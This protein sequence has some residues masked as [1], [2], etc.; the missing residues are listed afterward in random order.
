[1]E[2]HLEEMIARLPVLAPCRETIL[3][4]AIRLRDTYASGGK[5]LLCGNGGSAADA[6][7]WAGEMLKGFRLPRPLPPTARAQLGEDLADKLQG[8]LPTIPLCGFPSLSTAY[9]NDEDPQYV[10]AQLTWG[11]GRAEDALVAISTSGNSENVRLALRVARAKGMATI[12]LTGHGGG[13]MAPLCDL[14][15]RVPDTVTHTI[16]ELHLP[17]YHCLCL[18]V[19]EHFFGAGR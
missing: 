13:A 10:F 16:Q 9:A 2:R 19:E 6:E 12:G 11:L 3:A 5:V 14:C 1:M 15:V 17:V 7:H 18:M 4:V 8:A